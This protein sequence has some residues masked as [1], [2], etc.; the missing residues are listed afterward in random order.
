MALES[1]FLAWHLG[2]GGSLNHLQTFKNSHNTLD[3]LEKVVCKRTELLH[4]PPRQRLP[5]SHGPCSFGCVI[6]TWPLAPTWTPS[7]APRGK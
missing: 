1:I 2:A 7:L 6:P 4:S 3:S 5:S